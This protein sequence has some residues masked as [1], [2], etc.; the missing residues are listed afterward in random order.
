M[1]AVTPQTR[2]ALI[3]SLVVVALFGGAIAYQ[4]VSSPGG[5][6]GGERDSIILR[7][8]SHRLS[9]ADDDKVTIVEFL[10][11]ECEACASAYPFIEEMR[12]KYDGRVTFAL[13]YFPIDS[14]TN[15]RNAAHAVES[16]ARQDQLEGMYGR[17]YETQAEWGESQDSKAA[18]FRT[19]AED[20]GLDMARYDRDVKSPEVAARVQKDVDDGVRVGV[21]GTPSFFLNGQRLIPSTTQ[22]FVE[23]IDMALAR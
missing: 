12:E 17:M 5:A 15:A 18:L 14:H 20:L 3:F 6:D 1:K 21:T 13:R 16:A 19:Y 22:E 10:D 11:L 23:A 4:V 7:S 8:D 9:T 2:I